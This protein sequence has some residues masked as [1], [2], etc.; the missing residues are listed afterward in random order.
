MKHILKSVGIVSLTATM[1]LGFSFVSV[2]TA[3]ADT[4][5]NRA[6]FHGGGEL[7]P[8]QDLYVYWVAWSPRIAGGTFVQQ[9]PQNLPIAGWTSQR[10]DVVYAGGINAGQTYRQASGWANVIFLC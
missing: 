1:T 2:P 7:A 8:G 5:C 3:S 6:G 9:H 10:Y 4:L